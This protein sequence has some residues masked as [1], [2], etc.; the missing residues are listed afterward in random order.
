MAAKPEQ[1][2]VRVLIVDDQAPFR[3]A[4]RAVVE[5][6]D[7]FEVVGEAA[8][9]E[10]SVDAARALAPDLVLM[11]VRLPG[12]DGLEASRRILGHTH[13][14][15][16]PGDPGEPDDPGAGAR[17][18]R[19]PVVLLLSTAEAADYAPQAAA[20]GAAAFLPKAEFGPGS[21]AVAWAAAVAEGGA[22]GPRPGA[23]TPPPG[24]P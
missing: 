14:E 10:A 20:C 13:A 4:A 2:T 6:T 23:G 16:A 9:G 7:G 1:T 12:I 19:R 24:S 3:A 11:D 8:S 5:L 22:P 17:R 15:G 21:L 18:G